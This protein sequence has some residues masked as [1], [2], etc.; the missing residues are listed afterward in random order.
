MAFADIKRSASAA[1]KYTFRVSAIEG[2]TTRVLWEGDS[3]MEGEKQVATFAEA[4]RASGSKETIALDS[5]RLDLER[6]WCERQFTSRPPS[7]TPIRRTLGARGRPKILYLPLEFPTWLGGGHSWSYSAALAYERGLTRAGCDVTTLNTACAPF[8]KKVIRQQR[9]DQVW[10]H[11]HPRHISDFAFRQWV[12]DIAPVR[13]MLCGESVEYSEEEVA[14]EPWLASH[15][16]TAEL[17]EPFIT[18]AAFVDPADTMRLTPRI[19]GG[20][21]NA[22]HWLQAVPEKFVLPVNERPKRSSAVFVGTL[23]PPRDR[24]AWDLAEVMER[25]DSPESDT[26]SWLFEKSHEVIQRVFERTG[27][28][29]PWWGA[30]AVGLYN[31][32]QHGL[33]GHAFRNFLGALR[34]GVATVGLP[35]MVKTYSGRVVE[36]MAAGRPVL[37]QRI[38]G[39]PEVFAGDELLHY[40]TVEDLGESI[41]RLQREPAF[42]NAIAT[43]ARANLLAHHTVETRTAELLRFVE[44]RGD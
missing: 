25:L 17:W 9:Y 6:M 40:D 19:R 44:G 12:S 31:R 42:A 27:T 37:T 10:F 5:F 8:L 20:H 15:T 23:Y 26:F 2:S 30:K 3:M 33:R 34:D 22:M 39:H 32:F 36:G 14:R 21:V 28:R 1:H 29:A 18:H 16:R 24:W 13:L 38:P 41:R 4:A 11:C 35:S 7:V 43:R